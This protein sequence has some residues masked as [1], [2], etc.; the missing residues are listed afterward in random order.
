MTS[1]ISLRTPVKVQKVHEVCCDSW[2]FDINSDLVE[3]VIQKLRAI[4]IIILCGRTGSGKSFILRK[5][6]AAFQHVVQMDMQKL[7]RACQIL[8]PRSEYTAIL[9]RPQF[10]KVEEL[11]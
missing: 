5:I 8:G 11:G 6:A 9:H 2:E 3:F 4:K 1:Q 7:T 10:Y